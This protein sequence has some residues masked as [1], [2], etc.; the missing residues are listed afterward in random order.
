MVKVRA[1]EGYKRPQQVE[2]SEAIGHHLG[3]GVR[4]LLV[5]LWRAVYTWPVL[6]AFVVGVAFVWREAGEFAALVIALSLIGLVLLAHQFPESA[7][8]GLGHIARWQHDRAREHKE[9][10]LAPV[11]G[12][13]LNHK[14]HQGNVLGIRRVYDKRGNVVG[15]DVQGHGVPAEQLARQL[16]TWSAALGLD[17]GFH[18]V[19]EPGEHHGHHRVRVVPDPPPLPITFSTT[20]YGDFKAGLILGV[21]EDGRPLVW[22][23]K[24]APHAL[25]TGA[26]GGGKTY[27]VRRCVFAWLAAGGVCYLA[28]PKIT[29]FRD[30]VGHPGVVRREIDKAAISEMVAVVEAEMCRRYKR[31]EHHPDERFQPILLVLEEA[32]SL[33]TAES[34]RSDKAR[35]DRELTSVIQDAV[36]QIAILGRE[37][38]VHMILAPQRPDAALIGGGTRD[39][40]AFRVLQIRNC[41]D[42]TCEMALEMAR[43]TMIPGRVP[44]ARISEL[45]TEPGRVLVRDQDGYSVAQIATV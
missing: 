2:L 27:T 17:H 35:D 36:E 18:L 42:S 29:S 38:S 30:L 28:D 44:P 19:L 6:L 31:W 14:D 16:P 34:G 3:R 45:S 12:A 5:G 21:R 24:L 4:G 15:L 20:R 10:R 33:L 37:C 41:M 25:I 39:Q 26:T 22:I 8:G 32:Y 7:F 23:P 1:P 43:S 9:R 13:A 11:L 40:L